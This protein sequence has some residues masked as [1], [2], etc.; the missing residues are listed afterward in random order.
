M[1]DF[2]NL[3][4]AVFED[5]SFKLPKMLFAG[6]GDGNDGG[7]GPGGSGGA[8]GNGNDGAGSSGS[9]GSSGGDG[10][11]DG[12]DAGGGPGGAGSAD[13]NGDDGSASGVGG[14]VGGGGDGG[15]GIGGPSSNSD[16]GDPSSIGSLSEQSTIGN[17]FGEE[18]DYGFNVGNIA[19]PTFGG[20][21][22]GTNASSPTGN[23]ALGEIASE[24]AAAVTSV[25]TAKA[26]ISSTMANALSQTV[27]AITGLAISS[28]GEEDDDSVASDLA[29]SVSVSISDMTV[30]SLMA[31]PDLTNI[32]DVAALEANIA[33]S[34]KAQMANINEQLKTVK[35]P[36]E[37]V[38]LTD[39]LSVLAE[40]LTYSELYRFNFDTYSEGIPAS[41]EVATNILGVPATTAAMAA[42]AL[43]AMF[44]KVA[45]PVGPA[46]SEGSN[47]G[48]MGNVSTT[49]EASFGGGGRED[50]LDT[51]N[52]DTTPILE[53]TTQSKTTTRIPKITSTDS[54]STYSINTFYDALLGQ[55][56]EGVTWEDFQTGEKSDVEV[57]TPTL[58]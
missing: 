16:I 17:T 11:G 46:V 29:E 26:G 33:A 25:A 42:A 38:A 27:G 22:A 34:T 56:K 40:D 49:A 32:S 37:R 23:A 9:D 24:L 48:N 20:E 51:T 31:N 47:V 35:S 53:Q 8:D 14:G 19:D 55:R 13:G 1:M 45:S 28:I 21:L 58:I 57:F 3:I 18:S 2:N 43:D 5:K 15:Q 39:E 4:L 52:V 7:G 41:L 36:E 6:A 12:N 54:S 10:P 30:E 44:G 50:L